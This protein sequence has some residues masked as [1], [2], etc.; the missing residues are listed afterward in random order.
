[1]QK[2]KENAFTDA[3]RNFK[4]SWTY[5]RLTE[6]ERKG[7]DNSFSFVEKQNLLCGT[8]TQRWRQMNAIYCAFLYGCGYNNDMNWRESKAS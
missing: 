2:N 5:A 4:K 6:D 3:V 1:M 8:Y 7:L